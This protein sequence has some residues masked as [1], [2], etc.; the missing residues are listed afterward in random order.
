MLSSV[1]LLFTRT[2]V[3]FLMHKLAKL[4]AR[5]I[6]NGLQR[7]AVT[8]RSKWAETYRRMGQPF[9]GPWTFKWHPWL[10]EMHDAEEDLL[11]GQKAAQMGYTEWAMNVAFYSMDIRNFDVLY[12][13][14]TDSDAT[15]FSAGRFDPALEESPYLKTFFADVNNVGLKRSGANVLYVRGSRSRSKLKS[16]PTPVIIIDE[17]DEMALKN[18]ALAEERQSGQVET[19]TLKLSTPTTEDFGINVSFKLSSQEYFFFRCPSCNRHI[20]LT[21]PESIVITGESLTDP[22][23]SNS[24]YICKICK[25]RLEHE[26]KPDFLKPKLRGGTAEFVPT[27]TNGRGR[28]F[29]VNQMYSSAKAGRPENFAVAALKANLDPTYA[30]E[31]YNSKQAKTYT[32]PGAKITD[33]HLNSVTKGYHQSRPTFD[34]LR[35]RTLGIDVGSVLHMVIKEFTPAETWAPGFAV[36]DLATT[37]LVI[38]KESTGAATDFDEAYQ[39]FM[40]YRCYAGVVDAEPERRSAL[41][42]AQRLYGRIYLCDYLFTQ[43]GREVIV[44]EDELTI[45]C[46]RTSWL[47]LMFGRFKNKSTEIPIDVP[48]DY[49]KHIKEPTRIY[50]EDKFGNKYGVYVNENPDHYA[51]AET[52]CE[53]AYPIAYSAAQNVDIHGLF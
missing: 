51:H 9:P 33:E 4:M 29:L 18:L 39:L 5:Q 34:P 30:Q 37:R 44:N 40:D 2:D 16:I 3:E 43:Q 12:I 7:Q 26:N 25:A 14:P 41:Q 17:M 23:L 6:A 45:K 27:F 1:F 38:A 49:K 20:D 10:L 11:I 48:D 19:L 13:L 15:D 36:N 42:F 52:Y 32:A 53:L 24:Y 47:D 50:R 22:N 21:Y 28:G 35:V 46:N 8:K 31:F